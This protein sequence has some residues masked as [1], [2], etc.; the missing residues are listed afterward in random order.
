MLTL[1]GDADE[2]D[3]RVF[4]GVAVVVAATHAQALAMVV[5]GHQR[6]QYDGGRDDYSPRGFRDLVAVED[7]PLAFAVRRE[8]HV[9]SA[10]D[11]HGDRDA[12][13]LARRD[14]GREIHLAVP[15]Q[16][17]GEDVFEVDMRQDFAGDD[18]RVASL[19]VAVKG[20]PAA[21]KGVAQG[22]WGWLLG[23][24]DGVTSEQ[25]RA[26]LPVVRLP[27]YPEPF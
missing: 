10:K 13:F 9:A 22:S 26:C 4:C 8:T 25:V 6:C 1:V 12:P 11:W 17:G 24:R 27:G 19:L 7:Q 20:A 5:E 14:Q 16:I 18:G 3:A 23:W 2:L 15:G 21:A